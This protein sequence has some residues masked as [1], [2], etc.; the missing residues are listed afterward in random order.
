[1][2]GKPGKIL[3][4]GSGKPIQ[5]KKVIKLVVKLIGGGKPQFGKIRYKKNINMK[6]YPDISRAKKFL[7]WSPKQN[8]FEGLNLTINSYR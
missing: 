5:I 4:I 7:K 3:N 1:M 2:N 6:L 8:F